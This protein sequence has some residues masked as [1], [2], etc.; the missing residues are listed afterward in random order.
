MPK[1][2]G[3]KKLRLLVKRQNEKADM[4]DGQKNNI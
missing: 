1:V 2:K 3:L 4:A